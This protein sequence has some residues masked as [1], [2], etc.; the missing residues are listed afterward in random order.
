[1]TTNLPVLRTAEEFMKGYT[2]VYQPL[3]PLLVAAKSQQYAAEVGKL[4]FNR[5]EAVGD[6]RTKHI[7]PKDTSLA[8]LVAIEKSKTFKKYFMANQ[9]VRSQLQDSSRIEDVLAQVLDEGHKFQDELL[10][11]GEGTSDSTMVNNGLFWSGD[12]NYTL[13][14]TDAEI[15]LDGDTAD[16]AD[17]HR[18]VMVTAQK[19]D[20][21]A[22]RKLIIFYG[23]VVLPLFDSLFSTGVR[24]VKAALAETLG[25]NYSMTK[26]L[27]AVTPADESGWIIVN[28]D[29]QKLHYTEIPRLLSQGVNQEKMYT[30]HNFIQGSM[31]VEVLAKDAIIRQ[32]AVL[33]SEE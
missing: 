23:E 9:F 24:S 18:K 15:A 8:Q 6:I 33:A 28:I 19:A 21:V 14:G 32:P 4:S 31:M 27:E 1:M 17:F 22:G 11:L 29:Q 16:L 5:I 30:W 25:P 7:T 3:Y 10:L 26:M 12:P 13:E 2:P 20:Q